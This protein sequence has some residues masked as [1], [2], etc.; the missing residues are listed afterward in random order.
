MEL[1][2]LPNI[3]A[4]W[5]DHNYIVSLADIANT[6]VCKEGFCEAEDPKLLKAMLYILG[7]DINRP[8]EKVELAEG[9]SY[10]SPLT[11]LV[12]TG[13]YVYSGYERSDPSW[14]KYGKQNLMNYLYEYNEPMWKALGLIKE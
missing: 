1:N 3:D 9:Q 5:Y 11:D 6:R 10:R 14:K 13:G 4:K 2:P 12:Q 7:V 8:Y